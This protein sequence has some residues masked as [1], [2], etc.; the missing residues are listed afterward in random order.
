VQFG[1]TFDPLGAV[2]DDHDLLRVAQTSSNRLRIHAP[3]NASLFNRR[4]QDRPRNGRCRV[5]GGL[6]CGP[7]S[8]AGRAS[9]A[10]Y[11]RR[12]W[13]LYRLAKAINQAARLVAQ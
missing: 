2:A 6:S 8:K 9:I 4:S 11:Q 10:Q 12:R 5:H 3:E 7:K 13:E 1:K